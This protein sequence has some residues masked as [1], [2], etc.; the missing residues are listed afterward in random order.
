M[1]SVLTNFLLMLC[2]KNIKVSLRKWKFFEKG[3]EM[4]W[5]NH[6]WEKRQKYSYNLRLH[7]QMKSSELGIASMS[8]GRKGCREEYRIFLNEPLLF[9]NSWNLRTRKLEIMTRSQFKNSLWKTSYGTSL[10]GNPSIIF[11]QS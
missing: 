1:L 10:A 4:V 2:E 3:T 6:N 8:I 11:S 9:A 7:N 5:A